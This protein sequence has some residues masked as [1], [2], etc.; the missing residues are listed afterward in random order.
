MRTPASIVVASRQLSEGTTGVARVECPVERDGEGDQ[1]GHREDVGAQQAVAE[2]AA[3]LDRAGISGEPALEHELEQAVAHG[4]RRPDQERRLGAPHGGSIDVAQ[5]HEDEDDHQAG[6]HHQAGDG[7]AP[8]DGPQ[9]GGRGQ[10]EKDRP[11][12]DR[13]AQ[14]RGQLTACD[15]LSHQPGAEQQTQQRGGRGEGRGPEG[16]QSAERDERGVDRQRDPQGLAQAHD[17]EDDHQRRR[18][19]ELQEQGV[20]AL[21]PARWGRSS[22]RS[23]PSTPR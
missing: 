12:G 10:A 9:R 16:H 20:T 3:L 8:V 18:H 11:D 15:E 21:L 14:L 13:G 7:H 17:G 22:R 5:R 23:R 19:Q 2:P 1:Q 4:R 6:Q